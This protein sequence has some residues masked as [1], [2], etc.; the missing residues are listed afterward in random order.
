MWTNKQQQTEVPSPAPSQA[1]AMQNAPASPAVPARPGAPTARN[2]ACLGQSVQ[3]KGTI[4]GS[5]DMQI[6]GR[7]DGPV[8]FPGQR[9]TVGT[10]GQ[11]NS[12]ITAREIVVYGKVTG[13]LRAKDRVEIK[14]DG[15][16]VGDITTA[17]ISIEDGAYFKGKI[18]IEHGKAP[19]AADSRVE[20]PV[21]TGA[22]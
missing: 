17:R 5:E 6:D 11:L 18:E 10:S 9:L 14:K 22:N 4:T 12:E 13:N 3:I 2:L 1:P 15:S 16:V 8:S 19:A 21:L 20:E 7:V